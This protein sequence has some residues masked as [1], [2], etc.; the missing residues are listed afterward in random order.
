[1]NNFDTSSTGT[2]ITFG[3]S[4][5]T[6]MSQIY[7][8]DFVSG[9]S[10]FSVERFGSDMDYMLVGTD[11]DL[12]YWKPSQLKRMRKQELYD[13]FI[14]LE[15]GYHDIDVYKKDDL[16]F[17]LQDISIRQYYKKYYDE[18]RWHDLECDFVSRGYSQ[19]DAVKI[20]LVQ[21]VDLNCD[22]FDNLL[23]N[24][25]ISISLTVNDDD[26]SQYEYMDDEYNFD[27]DKFYQK[28][29]DYVKN[30]KYHDE[31]LS[32]VKESMPKDIPYPH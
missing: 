21:D 18:T 30:E 19:G 13:K 3:I 14:W 24:S 29:S 31:L 9:E 28:L 22:F 27:E 6:N 15:L 11:L 8:N 23:W 16:I 17:E 20:N 4:Y 5:D 25:P 7:Y 12:P 2:N 26:I 1:M 32:F 10:G